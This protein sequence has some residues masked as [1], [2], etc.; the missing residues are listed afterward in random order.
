[1]L[2]CIVYD[3]ENKRK[4]LKL[5]LHSEEEAL[6]YARNNKLKI[7][8]I[9]VIKDLFGR[10]LKNNDLKIFSKEMSILLKSGCEISRILKILISESNNRLKV[11][12]KE[13]LRDLEKGNTIE[14]SFKN[15]KAFST[16]YVSMIAAG[17]MSGNLD[18]V[19]DK[20]SIYY[21]KEEKLKNKII[22][23]MIYPVILMI[24]MIIS[25]NFLLFFLKY[26]IDPIIIKL[27]ASIRINLS[28][29]K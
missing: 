13:I 1:M 3:E 26:I 4:V 12:L 5:N 7:V 14:D 15:T 6:D 23:I 9:K 24:T 18:E 17:E 20:L 10:K 25:L 27:I 2:K 11:I 22:S 28:L 19:M 29:I 8:D 16:F 21:D